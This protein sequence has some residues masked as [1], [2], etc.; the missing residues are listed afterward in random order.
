[1]GAARISALQVEGVSA[2][3]KHFPGLG[4]APLDP[5]LNLPSIHMTWADLE[6]VHMVPF[7]RAMRTAVHSMMT[8]HPLYPDL[9]PTPKT[10]ATFSRKIVHDYLRQNTGYKGVIF[11]DDLEMGA[12]TELCSIGEAAVKT[13]AAGHDALLACHN[14]KAQRLV[15]DALKEAYQS[16]RLATQELEASVERLRILTAKRSERFAPLPAT[17]ARAAKEQADVQ[18]LL[19]EIQSVSITVLQ[20]G[21]A[22][23]ST[24]TTAVVF[25]RLSALADRI[26]IEKDQLNE[27]TFLENHS[28][29]S[30]AVNAEQTI[31]FVFDAHMNAGDKALLE[32]LQHSTKR[33]AVVLLRD[34]YDREFVKPGTLCLTNYGFRITD[35]EAVL[36]KLFVPTGAIAG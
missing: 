14:L 32:T 36:K 34:V 13:M 4:P 7:Y 12:I 21:P 5:H 25:P 10:P 24:G 3:A 1:M 30:V 27:K 29:V 28:A 6:K 33:L 16:K 23:S 2:C 17:P 20:E 19:H 26:M 15:F 11:S 22:L 35:I 18:T 8:S 31:L 9:D